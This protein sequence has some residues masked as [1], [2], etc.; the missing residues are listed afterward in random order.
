MPTPTNPPPPPPPPIQLSGRPASTLIARPS[1]AG[2]N[3][4]SSSVDSFFCPSEQ[5]IRSSHPIQRRGISISHSTYF[6]R[7]RRP[8]PSSG[9]IPFP[10]TRDVK[11]SLADG[12]RIP[13]PDRGA[14]RRRPCGRQSPKLRF[15]MA[16]T[17]WCDGAP[18]ASET[19]Q[20]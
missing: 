5:Q 20:P 19:R 3:F 1:C 11:R 6:A 17:S 14:P 10:K 4:R 15:P 8:L 12:R 16:W 9:C 18:P 7:A 2:Q 13:W